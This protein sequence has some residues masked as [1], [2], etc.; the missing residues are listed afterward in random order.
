MNL[1]DQTQGQGASVNLR[2]EFEILKDAFGVCFRHIEPS[3]L[4][5]VDAGFSIADVVP[6]EK[7]RPLMQVRHV[8]VTGDFGNEEDPVYLDVRSIDDWGEDREDALLLHVA[9]DE[10]A[11]CA[12]MHLDTRQLLIM[13]DGTVVVMYG[14][15]DD[16]LM[17]EGFQQDAADKAMMFWLQ[18]AAEYLSDLREW[19]ADKRRVCLKIEMYLE[20]LEALTQWERKDS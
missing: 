7:N 11:G 8:R 19:H 9:V 13:C 6:H 4:S 2:R 14:A 18:Y 15:W 12:A 3:P 20:A 1:Q 16:G 17:F 5:E 10:S